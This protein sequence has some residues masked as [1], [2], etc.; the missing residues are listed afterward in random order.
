M[1]L[2]A[3]LKGIEMFFVLALSGLPA[4]K[5][6]PMSVTGLTGSWPIMKT[7]ERLASALLKPA[8]RS[9]DSFSKERRIMKYM[10]V[11]HSS[12]SFTSCLGFF[13]SSK[14]DC[15]QAAHSDS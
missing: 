14:P 2:S 6:W 1:K 11:N 4:G 9:W 15:S 3:S 13:L 5:N 10:L 8:L 7:R 12:P